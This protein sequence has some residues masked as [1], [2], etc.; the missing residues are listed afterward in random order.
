M[1]NCDCPEFKAGQEFLA[2][3]Q[4]SICKGERLIVD[5]GREMSF[6]AS[7]PTRGCRWVQG[8]LTDEMKRE[9]MDK[10]MQNHGAR[11]IVPPCRH[12][13]PATCPYKEGL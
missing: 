3:N 10:A 8:P 13:D 11:S 9:N 2:L 12:G 7:S 1:K 4:E 6:S 5:P